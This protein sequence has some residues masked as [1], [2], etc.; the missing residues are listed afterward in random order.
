VSDST[1]RRKPRTLTRRQALRGM[2]VAAL[3]PLGVR[4]TTSDLGSKDEACLDFELI[5]KH[6]DTVVVLMMENRS[7]DHYLGSLTLLEGRDDVDGLTADM[8][9]PHPDGSD[10]YVFPS[11]V[12][13]LTD[14]PHSWDSS[15]AQFNDGANDQFVQQFSYRSPE[16]CHEAMGYWDRSVLTTFYTLADHYTVCDQWFSSL[17]SST[18]PNRFYSHAAQNGGVQGNRFPEDSVTTIYPRLEEAGW[19]WANYYANLP[20][21]VLVEGHKLTDPTMRFLEDFFEHAA[22]GTLP[23]VTVIDPIYGMADDHP[24]T[25]PVAGQLYVSMIYEA[26]AQSPQ[27]ERTLF[28]ITYDEHGGFYDHVPPPLAEDDYADEGFDQLGFRVPTLLVGPW[29]KPGAIYSHVCDH[30]SILA[31]IEGLFEVDPLTK[32]DA[33]ADALV[34]AFDLEALRSGIPREPIEL[35]TIEADEDELYAAEC[36]YGSAFAAGEPIPTGQPELEAHIDAHYPNSPKDRRSQTAEIY[37]WLL[38]G[39]EKK[40]LLKRRSGH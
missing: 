39:A 10:I 31:F 13:C 20:W 9:N 18:W 35:P 33:A 38:E 23:N 19:S 14:P 40:G 22:A 30:S 37:E 34:E 26:L 24:P 12:Y 11:E 3:G 8:S 32:R 28:I 2:G 36:S 17:M 29:L 7:F 27:W 4:C 25:H 1:K 6:V 21:L 16:Y 5:R 15:H